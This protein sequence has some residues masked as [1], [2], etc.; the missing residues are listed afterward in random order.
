MRKIILISVFTFAFLFENR[1]SGTV[2]A[3]QP[4][5]PY[6]TYAD[7]EPYSGNYVWR[8]QVIDGVYCRRLYDLK[9]QCWVDDWEPCPWEI[10]DSIE[11][12]Y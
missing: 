5:L 1:G 3:K 10:S 6:E 9:N 12:Q 8:Y 7:V 11:K 4:V 2:Y